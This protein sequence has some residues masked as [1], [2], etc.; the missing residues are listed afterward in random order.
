[1][2]QDK[3]GSGRLSR[4]GRSRE[5]GIVAVL[6]AICLVMSLMTSEFATVGNIM[7]IL[8]QVTLVMII[9]CSQT[10][11]ITSGGIDLSVG[12]VKIER[13]HV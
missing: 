2:R 9:A 13:A 6:A 12:F 10:F 1:M 4:L 8:K 3:N 5:I 11:V 7:N